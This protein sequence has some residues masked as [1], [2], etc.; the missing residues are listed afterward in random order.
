MKTNKQID[1][2]KKEK[3]EE[4]KEIVKRLGESYGNFG[5]TFDASLNMHGFGNEFIQLP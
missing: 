1:I 5:N 2:Q 4:M 3:R